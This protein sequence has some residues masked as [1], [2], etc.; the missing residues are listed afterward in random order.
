MEYVAGRSLDHVISR[1]GLRLSEALHYAVQI[2]D[3]LTKAHSAGSEDFET[4]NL[5]RVG[6]PQILKSSNR[7]AL[8]RD[9][10]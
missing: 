1:E 6:P 2:A 4:R 9:P 7:G 8:P 3:A 10:C 5:R